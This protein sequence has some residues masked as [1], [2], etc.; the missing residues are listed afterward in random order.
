MKKIIKAA[1]GI[2]LIGVVLAVGTFYFAS[3]LRGSTERLGIYLLENN[4]QVISDEEVVWY[5][6][7]RH[8][9]KLTGEAA[10]K[11]SALEVPVEGSPFVIKIGGEE[12]Y[13][14]SFW[15][16]FSSLS[17]SGV[18]IDTLRI[19]NDIISLDLG[20]P[21]SG[22]FDGADP[23]DDQRILDHFQKLGKLKQT[24]KME[25]DYNPPAEV[26][27]LVEFKNEG[28]HMRGSVMHI[29]DNPDQQS[30]LLRRGDSVVLKLTDYPSTVRQGFVPYN[31]IFLHGSG[32]LGDVACKE[33]RLDDPPR[34]A[35]QEDGYYVF[36][37]GVT[38]VDCYWF[39]E[40][41]GTWAFDLT[42]S[43]S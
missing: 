42:V 39:K 21:S 33:I 7:A 6:K 29:V 14:G 3:K 13:N 16:T 10:K 36:E 4:E 27:A 1:L 31:F 34:F 11:I 43:P 40:S 17:C 32:E 2:L 19:Q 41:V 20:Y 12:I 9:I 38:N 23:R 8:E 24:F 26:N 22:F 25:I 35:V 30:I 15:V 5:D 18:V 37:L 28:L